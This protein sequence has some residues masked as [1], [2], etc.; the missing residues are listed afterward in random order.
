MVVVEVVVVVEVDGGG[1]HG[2]GVLPFL[3]RL[4]DLSRSCSQGHMVP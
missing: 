3:Q 4:L 1:G 2:G